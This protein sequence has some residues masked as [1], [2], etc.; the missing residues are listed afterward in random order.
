MGFPLDAATARHG[1]RVHTLAG[2]VLG[3]VRVRAAL[4]GDLSPARVRSR[5]AV[6]RVV[7]RRQDRAH[8]E[9][10]CFRLRARRTVGA[11]GPSRLAVSE[12]Q[13]ACRFAG[14]QTGLA[15]PCSTARLLARRAPCRLPRRP[16]RRLPRRPAGTSGS[17]LIIATASR[18]RE[19]GTDRGYVNR[20]SK[21]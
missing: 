12:G 17:L 11:S 6:G 21:S 16:P 7:V 3:A 4:R 10:W 9:P 19:E 8:P 15:A 18:K 13:G 2:S 14:G 20:T 5:F 1:F